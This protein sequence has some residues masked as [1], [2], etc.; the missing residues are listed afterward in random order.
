[1][2]SRSSD[3]QTQL[4]KSIC[5]PLLEKTCWIGAVYQNEVVLKNIL[6]I[7]NKFYDILYGKIKIV[8]FLLDQSGRLTYS[9]GNFFS[10]NETI[11]E[12]F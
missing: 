7:K 8:I 11:K 4:W 3:L 1:M 10:E 5:P 12:C 6:S 2:P 9:D